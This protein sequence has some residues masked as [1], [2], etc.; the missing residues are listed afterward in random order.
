MKSSM[1][2]RLA[3]VVGLSLFPMIKKCFPEEFKKFFRFP[4]VVRE[5]FDEIHGDLCEPEA[6]IEMQ[7]QHEDIESPEFFPYPEEVRFR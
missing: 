1:I 6:W 7:K 5:E 4:E 2:G 3:C